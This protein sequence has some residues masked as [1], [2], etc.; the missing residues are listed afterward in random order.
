MAC[1]IKHA[2]YAGGHR[3]RFTLIDGGVGTID[4]EKE[5]W[6]EMFEPLKELEVF[7]Q[8]SIHPEFHTVCWPNGAD[9]APE[10]LYEAAV[11]QIARADA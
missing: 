10:Y 6:G 1:D 2:E 7:R 11:Q 4:L 5:L 8:F 3:I 9:L